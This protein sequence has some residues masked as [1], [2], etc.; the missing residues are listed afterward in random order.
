MEL[1]EFSPLNV[2]GEG[3][4]YTDV[5][6]FRGGGGVALDFFES[7]LMTRP[8]ECSPFSLRPGGVLTLIALDFSLP[9]DDFLLAFFA[10]P[11]EALEL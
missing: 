10:S 9:A 5:T 2:N 4:L 1:S 8:V 11:F 6:I 7:A 3:G